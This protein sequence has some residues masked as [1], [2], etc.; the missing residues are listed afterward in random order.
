MPND[1]YTEY[2]EQSDDELLQLASDRASLTD[3]AAAVLDAELG[4]RNL[5]TSDQ[6]EHQRF[7]NRMERREFKGRR[8]KIFG[9]R[10]FSWRELLSAFAA[11]AV[12]ACVYLVLPS[13]YHLKPDWEEAAMAVIIASVFIL[14]GWRK[15]RREIAFWTALILS[16][17]I[18]LAI[19]HGWVLRAGHLS[20]GGGKL[21]TLLGFAMFVAIYGCIRLIRRNFYGEKSSESGLLS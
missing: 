21:A 12:I 5:T 14:V 18:Q 11:L 8:R 6:G 16:S 17:A 2:A 3:E 1:L 9:K 20:R 4:R 10:Q 15:L 19:V 13:R 7:V